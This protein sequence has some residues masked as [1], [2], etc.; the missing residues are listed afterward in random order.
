MEE[1]KRKVTKE[2][3][4]EAII[5]NEDNKTNEELAK[6]MGVSKS[7]FYRYQDEY[8]IRTKDEVKKIAQRFTSGIVQQLWKNVKNGS[9]RAAQLLMEIGETYTPSNKLDL[10]ATMSIEY[11]VGLVRTPIEAGLSVNNM[12]KTGEQ[13]QLKVVN[14]VG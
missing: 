2:E 10:K 8:A 9:D 6:E 7:Q 3:F 13:K 4:T 11:S 1:F 14:K 12:I 5:N